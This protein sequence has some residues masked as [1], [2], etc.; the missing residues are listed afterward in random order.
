MLQ[1]IGDPLSVFDI[2][3][4]SRHGFDM[5]RIDHK[6]FKTADPSG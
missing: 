2:R 5:L 6:S 4:P 1:Q 3:L